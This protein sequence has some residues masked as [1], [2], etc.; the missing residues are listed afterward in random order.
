MKRIFA[1][2]LAVTVLAALPACAQQFPALGDD[3]T[4]SLGSFKIQVTN[5][6]A[7]MFAGCPGFNNPILSS[8]TMYD[9]VTKVGRSNAL[10]DGSAADTNGV[11][12]GTAGTNVS[13]AMLS[14]PAG[15]PCYGDG[16]CKS[17]A[18][19]REIHTEVRSLKMVNLSGGL[20]VV[21]AGVWY[22]NPNI[23]Q[24]PSK[25]SPG[26]VESRSGPGGAPANDLPGS[27]FFDIF[28]QVDIPACGGFP[29]ATVYNTAPLIVKNP[30]VNPLPPRVV[31]LH[32][33]SNVVPILFLRANPGK[34]N[35]NDIL[36]YFVL[37]GHGIGFTN[38]QSD[39]NEFNT[40]MSQQ[41]FT[42]V[43]TSATAA[44]DATTRTLITDTQSP[45]GDAVIAIS[46]CPK[47]VQPPQ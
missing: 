12:V 31:Y 16:T 35:A 38:S 33:T 8:P 15:Y 40:F 25:V 5:Q 41:K 14:A 6:F 20:P 42:C 45:T 26:E 13:E 46:P 37:A 17:G 4:S 3:N 39:V 34:W 29:G 2:V 9:P 19:T 1:I 36:G 21:R 11:P 44:T 18:N 23:Q 22:D 32:D 43:T 10:L 24:P 7:G 47:T 27:S 28:V 30:S